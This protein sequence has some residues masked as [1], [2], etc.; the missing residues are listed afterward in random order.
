MHNLSTSPTPAPQTGIAALVAGFCALIIAMGIGRFAYTVILPDMMRIYAF[1]EAVAGMMAG[2]NYVGYLAGALVMRSEKPG[3]RRYVLLA[4]W[5]VLSV[6]TTGGMGLTHDERFWHLLRFFSGV[7]SGG[8]FVLASAIVF[9]ALA[10][11]GRMAL[12]GFLYSGCGM[13]IA[14]GGIFAPLFINCFGPDGAWL[15]VALLCIPLAIF[16]GVYLHPSRVP[17]LPIHNTAPALACT[18]HNTPTVD[19]ALRVAFML[20]LVPY[21]LEG[22]GYSIGTTF[23]VTVVRIT[24]ESPALAGASWVITGLAAALTT[25]LWRLAA[26]RGGYA[27]MLALAF[28]LQGL[29]MLL[30]VFFSSAAAGLGSGLLLGATF[31][32]ITV[33]SLQYGV[34]LSNK[35]S[36]HTIAMMTV[37][38]GIGQIIGP[39]VAGFTAQGSGAFGF[40]F[41]VSAASLFL[42]LPFLW[43]GHAKK[44]THNTPQ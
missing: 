30:P 23:L 18:T 38:Y 31:L 11:T 35:P 20:L 17:S 40:S 34:S 37:I 27:P 10:A 12:S 19:N 4:F 13:G 2:G 16:A 36:A 7:A 44:K 21:F 26:V 15:G 9:D 29:G 25:P 28:A 5:L 43:L 33:L 1:D 8:V 41:A 32:G 42:A 39:F 14:L 24:T 6:L 22:F 3:M